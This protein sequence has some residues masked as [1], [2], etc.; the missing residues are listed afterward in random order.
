MGPRIRHTG[1][2]FS[3]ASNETLKDKI[4]YN[5]ETTVRGVLSGE[6]V[7]RQL[8]EDLTAASLCSLYGYSLYW[9]HDLSDHLAI[10]WQHKVLT[11]YED[12]I[13]AYN[14]V[15]A[16]TATLPVPDQLFEETIDSLNLLFPFQNDPTK[17]ILE[18]HDMAF[19]G[20]GYCG[21]PRKLLLNDY[22]YWRGRIANI[23][24][25]FQTPPIGIQQLLLDDEGKNFM[26]TFTFW[27]AVAAGVVALFGMGLAVA[28][29]IYSIK[30]YDLGLRQYE[31][32][33]VQACGDSYL[34]ERLPRLCSS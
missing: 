28:S 11:V 12:K 21:R 10:D 1:E 26:S 29:L 15:R 4:T 7:E 32:S 18:K 27:V 20:L 2:L 6:L 22:H 24:Q 25:I 34:R 19:Y 13:V 30:Q 31:L 16:G 33:I 17:K 8:Q 5:F 14:H 23:Q 3:W 9:T